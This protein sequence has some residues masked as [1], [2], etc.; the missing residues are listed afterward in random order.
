MDESRQ[1]LLDAMDERLDATIESTADAVTEH[2]REFA[3]EALGVA[4]L[5]MSPAQL[6][7]LAF[8]ATLRLVDQ[9]LA[10]SE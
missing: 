4:V 2:D 8:A 10:A 7:D 3:V 5:L 1:A 9:E 6:T